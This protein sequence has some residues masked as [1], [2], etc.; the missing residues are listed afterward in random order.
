MNFIIDAHNLIS[1]LPGL[2]L[3]M[4]DDEQRLIELLIRYAR[5]GAHRVEVYFDAAPAGQAGEQSFGRV[6]AH[7]VH[8]RRTADQAIRQKV[9]S[10]RQASKNW[11]VVSSDLSVQVA[12]REAHAGVMRAEDFASQLEDSLQASAG[13]SK[14]AQDETLSEAEVKEWLA[15]F[16]ARSKP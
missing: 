3:S 4:P 10:L 1:K 16:K 11:V 9:R 7:F 15:I 14:A 5:T 13:V 2:D 8:Q 6:R 12:A